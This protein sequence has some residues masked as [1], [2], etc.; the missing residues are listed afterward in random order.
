MLLAISWSLQNYHKPPIEMKLVAITI[1]SSFM[2]K[3]NP[4]V[5]S[6]KKPFSF[7]RQVNFKKS[8]M[9]GWFFLPTIG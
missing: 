1:I 4:K 8:N 5:T 3:R 9:I 2:V 6:V 7:L